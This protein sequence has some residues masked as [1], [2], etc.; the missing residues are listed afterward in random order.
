MTEPKKEGHSSKTSGGVNPL[1]HK[2]IKEGKNPAPQG[3]RPAPPP[4]P[5]RPKA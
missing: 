5:P 4:A 1:P 2:V 3:K